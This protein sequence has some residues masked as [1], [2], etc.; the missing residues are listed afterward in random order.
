MHFQI[1]VGVTFFSWDVLEELIQDYESFK[2]FL[3]CQRKNVLAVPYV[4]CIII[5][6][7]L[8]QENRAKEGSL[9][10]LFAKKGPNCIIF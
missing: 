7:H 3:I 5:F 10:V 9:D 8:K 4:Q 2:R 6:L 1:Y